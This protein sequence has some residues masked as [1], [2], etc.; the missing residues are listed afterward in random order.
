[1]K[2]KGEHGVVFGNIC[3]YFVLT[4]LLLLRLVFFKTKIYRQDAAKNRKW[5]RGSFV[6]ISNHRSYW[7]GIVIVLA[8]FFHRIRFLATD[9]FE[10][11]PTLRRIVL[12]AGGIFLSKDRSNPTYMEECTTAAARGEP[13]LIFPEGAYRQSFE[14]DSFHTGY[15][16]IALKTGKPIVPVVNDFNYGIFKRVHLMV[17]SSIDV[18]RYAGEPMSP[19]AVRELSDEI[20]KEFLMLFYE[21]KRAK[22]SGLSSTYQTAVPV[23]GDVV[24]VYANSHYHYGVYLNDDEV[25]QFGCAG[26]GTE[27]A[28]TIGVASLREFRGVGVTEVRRLGKGARKLARDPGDV[29]AY[30]RACIGAGGYSET[31][32][33]C[34]DFADRVTLKI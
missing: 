26:A 19:D 5:P 23:K 3:Y 34:L 7:D 20:R 4:Q 21:L 8:M 11:R 32:N 22:A 9:Y 6:I 24:R 18:S 16:R 10:N 17:G 2:E 12:I 28:V 29:E 33:S 31:R 13:I 15:V 27:G 30:A 1:M 25:I 14:P